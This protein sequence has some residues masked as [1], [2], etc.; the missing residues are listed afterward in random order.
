MV[1][2]EEDQPVLGD[3]AL[4][5]GFALGDASEGVEVVAHDPGGVEVVVGG[6][7]VADIAGV[8]ALGFDVDAEHAGGVA[9]EGFD[10]D[11]FG[12]LV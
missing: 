6:D 5:E 4:Q 8:V 3:G 11:A 12:D 9:G 7:E 10:P 1:V 2:G